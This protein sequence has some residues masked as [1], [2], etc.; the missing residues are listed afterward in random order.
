MS[1]SII[2]RSRQCD[3]SVYSPELSHNNARIQLLADHLLLI[4]LRSAR[5]SFV[6]GQT[7]QSARLEHG[8]LIRLGDA[9]F[10]FELQS[11]SVQPRLPHLEP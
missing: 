10:R 9:T 7:V 1:E 3:I 8:D 11:G 4:H 6:N 5:G 2:G